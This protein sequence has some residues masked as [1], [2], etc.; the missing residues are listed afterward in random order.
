[1]NINRCVCIACQEDRIRAAANTAPKPTTV[2]SRLLAAADDVRSERAQLQADCAAYRAQRDDAQQE[3]AD[4]RRRLDAA[5]SKLFQLNGGEI[6]QLRKGLTA[7]TGIIHTQRATIADLE[8]DK[9]T[10]RTELDNL[11]GGCENLITRRDLAL[12][13]RDTAVEQVKQL[14][15]RVSDLAEGLAAPVQPGDLLELNER[16]RG[17]LVTRDSA[18]GVAVILFRDADQKIYSATDAA[19]LLAARWQR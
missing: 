12:R 3:A 14:T 5:E 8:R 16:V 13:D 7:K 2:D 18:S 11:R 15:T 9:A 6:D 1:M 17:V 10:L 4:L 19:L